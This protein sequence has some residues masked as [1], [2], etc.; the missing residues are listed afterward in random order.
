MFTEI[1]KRGLSAS[2]ACTEAAISTLEELFP[3][4]QQT[5][6][7]KANYMTG[8]DLAPVK[9]SRAMLRSSRKVQTPAAVAMMEET[10]AKAKDQAMVS[11]SR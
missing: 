5:P 2:R 10:M 9:S 11:G 7:C 6:R 4:T 1:Q 3:N 8:I